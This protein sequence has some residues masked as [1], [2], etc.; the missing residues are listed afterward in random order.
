MQARFQE[1]ADWFSHL[2]PASLQE[3]DSIYADQASF[4]DPFNEIKGCAQV[5]RV[6]QHM[7]DHLQLAR[8]TIKRI[9]AQGPEAF[10]V[11]DFNFSLRNRQMQ[12]HGCTH[13]VLD[14]TGRIVLHRDYWDAAEE[15]YEKLPLLGYFLRVLKRRLAVESSTFKEKKPLQRWR[16]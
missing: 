15:L 14:S 7:F 16:G 4:R 8:F 6:Y 12:I 3:I 1:I 5:R 11:W 10:M 2:Q 9:V 13:F